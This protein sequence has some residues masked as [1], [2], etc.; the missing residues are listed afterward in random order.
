MLFFFLCCL[1]V[2]AAQLKVSLTF[3]FVSLFSGGWRHNF[4]TWQNEKKLHSIHLQSAR[5]CEQLH[6]E[7]VLICMHMCALMKFV[8][9]AE[10]VSYNCWPRWCVT[11]TPNT[12]WR[13]LYVIGSVEL[14]GSKINCPLKIRGSMW[15]KM[16]WCYWLSLG[17]III[18]GERR[19]LMFT[20]VEF[21]S[22]L[23]SCHSLSIHSSCGWIIKARFQILSDAYVSFLM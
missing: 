19:L 20:F 8:Q 23:W 12:R 4:S 9:S 14:S 18:K 1:H 5:C 7:T 21:V 13:H 16:P 11:C 6:M 2:K 10:R 15:N 17:W 22:D 3:L